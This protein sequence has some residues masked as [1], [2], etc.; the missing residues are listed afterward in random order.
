MQ[1]DLWVILVQAL[2]IQE[3]DGGKCGVTTPD[4]FSHTR[5]RIQLR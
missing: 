1:P 5:A 3:K 4:G 2:V